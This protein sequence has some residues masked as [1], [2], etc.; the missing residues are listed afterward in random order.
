[1]AQWCDQ[2]VNP[3]LAGCLTSV[4][5]TRA[6]LYKVL[7]EAHRRFP[8]V[9]IKSWIDDLAH[10]MGGPAAILKEKMV[11]S[12]VFLVQELRKLGCEISD[13]TT[14]I[15]S[16]RRLGRDIVHELEKESIPIKQRD[17]VRDIG[18]D[19]MQVAR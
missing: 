11:A 7:D 6:L 15:S 1:M 2:L 8:P 3:I 14:L 5:C 12:A 9:S 19:T 17:S 10:T 4:A 13:K 16:C 18:A